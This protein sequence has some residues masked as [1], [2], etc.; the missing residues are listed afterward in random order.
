[1]TFRCR[2]LLDI[3]HEMPCQFKLPHKCTQHLGCVPV[4][5]NWLIFGKGFA[6]KAPDWAWAA[7]CAAAHAEI[8]PALG[9]TMDREQRETEWTIAYIGTQNWL[10]MNERVRVA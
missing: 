9:A 1:M 2:P 5:S 6:H 4:H 7:G 8:D 3:S 10:W